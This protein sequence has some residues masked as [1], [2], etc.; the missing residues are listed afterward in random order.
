MPAH[1]VRRRNEA[2]M[3]G[4][5]KRKQRLEQ[6]EEEEEEN[7]LNKSDQNTNPETSEDNESEDVS[8]DES[9][10]NVEMKDIFQQLQ[11]PKTTDKVIMQLLCVLGNTKVTFHQFK[12]SKIG[13]AVRHKRGKPGTIGLLATTI[14]DK[15]KSI[16]SQEF[17]RR[18]RE[19]INDTEDE[20]NEEEEEDDAQENKEEG[21]E[22]ESEE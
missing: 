17:D 11:N 14:M 19:G 7:T 4:E 2:L 1:I 9:E 22:Q 12:Y 10:E 15:W 18:R 20:I 5:E 3:R 8:E 6:E 13:M 16:L 21:D